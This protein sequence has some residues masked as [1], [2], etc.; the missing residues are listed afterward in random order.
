MERKELEALI[1]EE[2]CI[3]G[4]TKEA[5][6]KAREVLTNKMNPGNQLHA[7]G[8]SVSIDEFIE[9]VEVL[10]SFALEHEDKKVYKYYCESDCIYAGN[11][12]CKGRLVVGSKNKFP[13]GTVKVCPYYL[14][15]DK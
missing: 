5:C 3:K 2:G 1:K 15:E 6:I 12:N 7:P 4:G 14:E 13:A 10:V 8:S 9:A 11:Q